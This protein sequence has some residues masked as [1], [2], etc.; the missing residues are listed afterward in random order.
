MSVRAKAIVAVAVLVAIFRI[1]GFDKPSWWGK[2]TVIQIATADPQLAA[3]RTH[4]IATLDQFLDVALTGRPGT[5]KYAVKI[6][7]TDGTNTEVFWV[8]HVMRSG[9]GRFVGRIDNKPESVKSVKLGQ[10]LNFSRDQ[11][12]DWM[13]VDNGRMV[14][15]F[16]I[17][18]LLNETTSP[19][20]SEVK[21]RFG[22]D[23]TWQS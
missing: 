18:V 16:S 22:V 19:K 17:C 21:Q 1:G 8:N 14:G 9:D 6:P 23:C 12:V 7:L 15:N 5:S 10:T 2:D 20:L 13:Y 4:A 3:S 11:I